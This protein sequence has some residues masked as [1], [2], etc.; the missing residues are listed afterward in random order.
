MTCRCQLQNLDRKPPTLNS[1]HE[2]LHIGAIWLHHFGWITVQTLQ[3]Y[4][5][6]FFSFYQLA[7]GLKP[8]VMK[9]AQVALFLPDAEKLKLKILDGVLF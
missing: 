5:Q 1:N 7:I 3:L 4:F 9:V 6:W 8:N 2:Y